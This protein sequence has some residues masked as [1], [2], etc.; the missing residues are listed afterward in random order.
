MEYTHRYHTYPTQ[1]VAERL[2]YHIDVHRQAYSYALSVVWV[3]V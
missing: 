2:E 1:E 3:R